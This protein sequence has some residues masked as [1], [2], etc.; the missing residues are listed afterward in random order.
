MNNCYCRSA[1][2][3]PGQCGMCLLAWALSGTAWDVT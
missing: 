3:K 1:V 2:Q